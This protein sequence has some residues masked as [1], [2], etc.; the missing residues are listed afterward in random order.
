MLLDH[1]GKTM[2]EPTPTQIRLRDLVALEVPHS[3][4]GLTNVVRTPA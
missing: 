2:N 1:Q 4:E 3:F